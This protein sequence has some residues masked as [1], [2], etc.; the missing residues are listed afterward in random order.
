MCCSLL[1]EKLTDLWNLT[2]ILVVRYL[3]Y[4]L[5]KWLKKTVLLI[6]ACWFNLHTYSRTH[7]PS[8]M[9]FILLSLVTVLYAL[10][11]YVTKAIIY[12]YEDFDL[13]AHL[14]P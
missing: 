6:V 4:R 10:S 11:G 8:A 13:V 7:T 2:S 1:S 3:H 12:L 9:S 5:K 14:V